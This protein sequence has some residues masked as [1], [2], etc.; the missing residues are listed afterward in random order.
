M[1]GMSTIVHMANVMWFTVC[2]SLFRMLY[3]R[4]FGVYGKYAIV[5]E[6]GKFSVYNQKC[7]N[8]LLDLALSLSLSLSLSL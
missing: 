6:T 4:R 3:P 2:S 1:F 7:G 8:R 5:L